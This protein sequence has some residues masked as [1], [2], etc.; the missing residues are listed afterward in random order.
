MI[1]GGEARNVICNNVHL[2][3]ILRTLSPKVRERTLKRMQ[4]ILDGITTAFGGSYTCQLPPTK[5]GGLK[6]PK[7]E[8]SIFGDLQLI[9]IQQARYRSAKSVVEASQ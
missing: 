1:R 2:E 8:K 6:A 9:Q 5:V 3:G 7:K 4:T